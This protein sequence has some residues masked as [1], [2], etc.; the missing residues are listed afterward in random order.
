MRLLK[1]NLRR[2]SPFYLQNSG[3]DINDFWVN[4]WFLFLNDSAQSWKRWMRLHSS[5]RSLRMKS[6]NK[7]TVMM[8]VAGFLKLSP[9]YLKP[10]TF[11]HLLSSP[12]IYIF[13]FQAPPPYSPPDYGDTTYNKVSLSPVFICTSLPIMDGTGKDFSVSSILHMSL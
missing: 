4:A 3:R 10:C 12:G 13:V 5:F 7:K 1:N 9:H 2:P 8:Q 11:Q 6:W